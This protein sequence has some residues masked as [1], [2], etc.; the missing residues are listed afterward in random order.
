MNLT[1][2]ASPLAARDHFVKASFGGFAGGGKTRTASDFLA[3]V[4]KRLGCK[5]PILIID[6][7]KGS[8][9]LK[10]FFD[11]QQIDVLLKETVHL[12]DVL[13][14]FEFLRKGDISAVFIDSL[15]KVYYQY[16]RDYRSANKVTFMSLS[17]WGK[18]L[19]EWQEKFANTMVGIS[20]N[21]VFTGRG[22]HKY[23]MEEE[24]QPDGR[25]KKN[26]VQAGVKMKIPG[27]T[28]FETDINVWMSIA[29]EMD[30]NRPIVWREA[31]VMKDR[32]ATIDGQTFKN[33]SFADFKPFVDYVCG[34]KTG[35]VSGPS[36]QSNL[37]PAENRWSSFRERRDIENEK[38]KAAFDILGLSSN[39]AEDK[40]LKVEITKRVFGTTSA[41]EVERM[42]PEEL[43]QKRAVLEAF[44]TEWLKVNDPK[45]RA[46]FV[47]RYFNQP[48][49][50][51]NG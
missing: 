6:N 28:P 48:K 16:V 33:P 5:K 22:G 3:G 47:E 46:A 41:T 20:G 29:Q 37:V 25:I 2:F 15:T 35:D 36:D 12:A 49:E 11:E 14:A 1:D 4:Y 17:D 39:G 23:E 13:Q 50:T 18:V 26:F 40:R 9:F 38:I 42:A 21:I 8:R 32:S 31:F 7:E 19:P 34:I 24:E 44:A 51:T 27:E 45:E 43:G 10:P 30:G